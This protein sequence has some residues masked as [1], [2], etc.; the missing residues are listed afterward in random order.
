MSMKAGYFTFHLFLLLCEE[1]W[2][3]CCII[4]IYGLNWIIQ[5]IST[6]NTALYCF[7]I[8]SYVTLILIEPLLFM[9]LCKLYCLIHVYFI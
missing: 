9:T 5:K 1:S 4:L 7:I 8:C 6:Y 3:Y 2:R